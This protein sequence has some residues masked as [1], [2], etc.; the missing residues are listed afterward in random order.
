MANEKLAK[1]LFSRREEATMDKQHGKVFL[2][3]KVGSSWI[4]Q[5]S[6]TVNTFVAV[7]TERK[8]SV[9]LSFS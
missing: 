8:N 7:R 9:C 1:F 2:K 5:D 4:I 6:T 3:I